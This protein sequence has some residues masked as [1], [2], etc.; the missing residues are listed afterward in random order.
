VGQHYGWFDQLQK[1][2]ETNQPGLY[3]VTEFIDGDTIVV[4]MG[5]TN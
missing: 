1:V 4:D 5:G 2:V 3:H